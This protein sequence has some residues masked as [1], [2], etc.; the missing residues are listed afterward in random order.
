MA[1]SWAWWGILSVSGLGLV[2]MPDTGP[3]LFSLSGEH[4]PSL[5]DGVGVLL[6]VAGWAILDTATW[7]RRYGLRVGREVL[8]LTAV[9][10][11]TASGL[12]LWSVLGDHG[13]WWVAGATVLAAIQLSAAVMATSRR[14]DAE[15]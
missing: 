12:V 14:G 3:R 10:G 4:G 11:A 6:L 13:A 2:L 1:R 15:R 5:V 7:R 9:G 8:V